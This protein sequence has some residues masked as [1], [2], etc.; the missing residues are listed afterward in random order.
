MVDGITIRGIGHQIL[1]KDLY[2][3]TIIISDMYDMNEYVALDLLCRAQLQMSFYPGLP[4]GLVAIILYYSGRKAL[5]YSLR[6]LVQ[7]RTG[8]LW[9]VD[10]REEVEDILMEYTD[11][12]LKNGLITRILDLLKSLDLSQEIE[13]LQQNAALGGPKHRHQVIGLFNEIRLILAETV[14]LWS[15]N[16]GLPKEPATSLISYIRNAQ[17]EE[18]ASGKLSDV[19]M[20]LLIALLYTMD[21]SILRVR[22][23][24]EEVVQNLP[25]ISEN[26]YVD[27][28]I[29][30]VA[31]SKSKWACEGLKS[32]VSFGLAV[33]LA[34]IRDSP[35][36]QQVYTSVE[37]EENIME[38]AIEMGVFE[39]L[40]N[41]V[42]DNELIQKEEFVVKRLHNLLADFISLKYSKV[43]E[44]RVQADDA[45]RTVQAYSNEGLE[46]PAN[47]PRHFEQFL[48]SI[49]KLYE[50]DPLNL[51][52]AVNFWSPMDLK[53]GQTLMQSVTPKSS[54]S[55]FKFIKLAGEFLPI[56]LFVPY[57][58]MLGSLA[59]TQQSARHCFNLLKSSGP[60][61][62]N[63]ISWDHFFLTFNRYYSSLHQETPSGPVYRRQNLFHK[64]I[65]PQEIE[66]LQ[67]VLY[68]IRK[69]ADNDD[70]SR[71]ALCEHPGWAPLNVLLGLVSCSVPVPLKADL[72]LTLA[73]LAKL[74]QIAAQLWEMLEAS[75]ILV[76]I[77][78]TSN[79]QPRGIQTELD[80]I[81]SN[82]EE[83]PLTRAFLELLDVLT[84]AGIP[85]MLG[86]GPRIPGFD[87][88]LNFIISSVFLKFHSRSYKSQ[89]EKWKVALI[90]LKLLEKFVLKYEPNVADFPVENKTNTFNSPPGYHLMLQLNMKS[91][92]LNLLIYIIDEGYRLLSLYTPFVG[93]TLLEECTLKCLTIL[94]HALILQPKFFAILSSSS[95]P[96]L[97]T[98]LAK[99][100]LSINP[101]S[102]RPDCCLTVAKYADFQAFLP[103]HVLV[104]VNVL[105]HVT[106]SPVLHTQLSN[107]LFVSDD[108]TLIKNNFI[109]CLEVCLSY[110]D[111][112]IYVKTKQK[113][114]DLLKQCLPYNSPNLTH[115]FLGFDLSKDI[116][117][118]QFQYPGVQGFP[119]TCLHSL[120]GILKSSFTSDIVAS[121]SSLLESAYHLL[122]LLVA[123]AKTSEPVLRLIRMD[124]KF[125]KEHLERC[126]GKVK[127]GINDLNQLSWFLKTMAVEVKVTC[128]Q[129]QLFYLKQL[130]NLL[131]N[132][133]LKNDDRRQDTF[134]FVPP[135]TSSFDD[136]MCV[137]S[138]SRVD[139]ILTRLIMQ[140]DFNIAK[141]D[142]PRWEYFD[143]KVLN[144]IL[145]SCELE[146]PTRLLDLKRLHQILIDELN[147]LRGN[148]ALGQR[149]AVLEEIQK[150]FVYAVSLNDMKKT[151]E[152]VVSFVDGWCQVAEV[153][154]TCLPIET[155]SLKEQQV[156][157]IQFLEAILDKAVKNE[158]LPELADILSGTIVTLLANIRKCLQREIKYVRIL[159]RPLQSMSYPNIIKAHER[160]IKDIFKNLVEW[161]MTSPVMLQ[162]LRIH[163]YAA[164]VHI[165]H[166]VSIDS[167]VVEDVLESST[168]VSRLDSSKLNRRENRSL[169][170]MVSDVLSFFGERFV[171][172]V[173]QDCV[174]GSQNICKILSMAT[175]SLLVE[176]NGSINW[177]MY[178]SG[179]GY[180]KHIIDSIYKSD[181]DL[182]TLLDPSLQDMKELLIY[183]SRMS[184]LTRIA[185]TKVGAELL[186]E[187][188]LLSYLSNMKLFGHH[189]EIISSYGEEDFLTT[190]APSVSIRYI[191]IWLPTF[192]VC[193]AVLTSLGTDNQ[194]AVMQITHYFLSQLNILELVL[195]AGKPSLPEW[196]L[197]EVT[198]LTLIIART[199]HNDLLGVLDS[200]V[201]SQHIRSL[202]FRVQ[203]LMLS[204][205]PKFVLSRL[206]VKEAIKGEENSFKTSKRLL[207][208]LQIISNLLLYARNIVANCGMDHGAIGVIFQPALK[209]SQHDSSRYL[210][211]NGKSPSL[212]VILEHLINTVRYQQEE[213]QTYIFLKKQ[214]NDVPKMSTAELKECLKEVEDIHNERLAKEHVMAVLSE[215]LKNKKQEMEYCAFIIE[216][217]LYIIWTH[218][219]YYMLKAIPK[220]KN[221]G[222]MNLSQSIN[223]DSKYSIY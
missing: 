16:S 161:L 62:A 77:P 183:E 187:Q 83:Y 164:A 11:D 71:L 52:L 136:D 48:L 103:N 125:F 41:A 154:G 34:C 60:G 150:V 23:D 44:L 106:Q 176:V 93:K 121:Q 207:L 197:K 100:L 110:T 43:K 216:H 91:D 53:S 24:G 113:I 59:S 128:Q 208:V 58:K 14:F 223:M 95:S 175:F 169:I 219:D 89:D 147:N 120:L 50:K 85:R 163:L 192:S 99:L 105:I 69:V 28:L 215:K 199:A 170:K 67:A 109:E 206:V 200:E 8:I 119:R 101:R 172:C 127:G 153:L 159:D 221:F 186:L 122:Y 7:A 56:T 12:L 180:L 94:E 86:A 57:L 88:Y 27:M 193:S 5:A 168:Y 214:C 129:R 82:M 6:M 108:A 1:S 15:A 217:C 3:E 75:Q 79:Y 115:F 157:S 33:C 54:H 222:F 2:Q 21:L 185:T 26:G 182:I 70:F 188:K 73:S 17:L 213:K 74:P 123:D 18:E 10:M 174:G 49:S 117:K 198:M 87:P 220:A 218:L 184:L 40:N 124:Q 22:E 134:D 171:E 90:C 29:E 141:V 142:E 46:P 30:E 133:P 126:S 160:T 112:E 47:L 162:K 177:I 137:Y 107:I 166:I 61:M 104:A 78:S 212:G 143:S 42:F 72:L 203:K 118:M 111:T 152:S 158:L 140:F 201:E 9:R 116:N 173:A 139:N 38:T 80:E 132:L 84:D 189:P 66:G 167:D 37:Q 25:I 190:I 98:S 181:E 165:L 204:L 31:L 211:Y 202:L 144:G 19:N 151:R 148:I 179:K 55:L 45:A 205:L 145:K 194:S 114:L 64:G 130:T 13:K 209:D 195:R 149:Q 51:D 196:S 97:L 155:L 96:T 102:R 39:F 210:D 35:Q 63:T 68:V 65:T 156:V 76:T 146:E 81:E 178:A 191:R 4:R 92:F 20:F 131:V 36:S 138:R 32:V 135:P